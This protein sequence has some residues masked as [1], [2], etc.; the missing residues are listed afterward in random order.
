MA[1][2]SVEEAITIINENIDYIGDYDK[3][4]NLYSAL[5]YLVI[6]RPSSVS[7]AGNSFSHSDLKE[8]KNEVMQYI[9]SA[10]DGLSTIKLQ[11]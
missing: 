2:N 1:I 8:I 4:Y 3:A 11:Y 6:M 7:I 10:D 9:T 5:N